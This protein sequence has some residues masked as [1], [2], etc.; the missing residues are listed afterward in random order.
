[1]MTDDT[2]E[3]RYLICKGGAYYRPNAAGYTRD[4]SEAGRYTLAEAI[5]HSH[6]NGSDGPRDGISYEEDKTATIPAG[7]MADGSVSDI[8]DAE[9][10][11]RVVCGLRKLPKTNRGNTIPLWSCVATRFCLGSTYSAQLCRRFGFDPD[12]RVR[13]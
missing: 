2:A 3:R 7:L 12:E 13:P 10:I 1:M 6:P 11:R 9:L 8:G 5:Y 4:R